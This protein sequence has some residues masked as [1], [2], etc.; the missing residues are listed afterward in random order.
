MRGAFDGGYALRYL[1]MP[2]LLACA[3]YVSVAAH[4]AK[5]LAAKV[6]R[7]WRLPS[8]PAWGASLVAGAVGIA[9][10]VTARGPMAI[11]DPRSTTANEL[12]CIRDAER[13][14]AIKDG[15][16]TVL[17]ARYA[18]AARH[19]TDWKSPYVVVQVGAD[20][21]PRINPAENNVLWFNNGYRDGRGTLNF[22]AT[23][24]LD[25]DVLASVRAS[26]G[27]PDR[28]LTCPAALDLRPEGSRRSTSGFGIAQKPS[29]GFSSWQRAIT[30]EARSHPWSARIACLSIS[31]GGKSSGGPAAR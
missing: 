30:I 11:D 12:R 15:L 26:I 4:L 6:S 7:T 18:N 2:W 16:G 27:L 23:Q 21:P 8:A 31:N 5:V 10:I 13:A 19:A 25:D 1:Q 14:G 20:V 17:F 3:F 29:G 9:L 28:T 22:L 24:G